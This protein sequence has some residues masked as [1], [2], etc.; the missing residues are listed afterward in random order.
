MAALEQQ[1][2]YAT[3]LAWLAY[4]HVMRVGQGWSP[5]PDADGQLAERYAEE[6]IDCEQLEPMAL[7]VRGHVWAYLRKDFEEAFACFDKALEINANNPRAWLWSAAAH[8][9]S[10]DGANAV[11]KIE[12]AMSLAPFDPLAFAYHGIASMAYLA[13]GQYERAIEFALR[14]KH[15]NP[16]YT[17]A[18]RA[19][20]FA[21]V[22]AGRTS[23][24][25][26]PAL[27]LLQLAPKF[28]VRHFRD[29][30]PVC[31]GALGEACCDALAVA[32]V[33]L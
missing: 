16:S 7:A 1:P 32:G 15:G 4:W 23:E 25:A 6:A 10:G 20:I 24:A 18:Y 29:H 22:L 33:P 9:W 5:D 8:A 13:N 27:K 26:L 17:H 14:C 2:R 12:R 31:A 3:A 21:L 28:T 11:A 19:L 30:S